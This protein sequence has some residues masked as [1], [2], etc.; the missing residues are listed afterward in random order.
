MPLVP[1]RTVSR[2]AA[3]STAS[4]NASSL[5]VSPVSSIV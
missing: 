2:I 4:M 5:A 3:R 1:V